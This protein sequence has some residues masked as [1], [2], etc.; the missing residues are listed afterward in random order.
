MYW[1]RTSPGNDGDIAHIKTSRGEDLTDLVR[2]ERTHG[3]QNRLCALSFGH[4]KRLSDPSPNRFGSL[5]PVEFDLATEEVVR[6]D[7][8]EEN[9]GIGGCRRGPTVA[10]AGW[11]RITPGRLWTHSKES[12]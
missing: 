10:V 2:H 11:T 1:P 8:A 6:V 9:I 4:T 7:I 5:G 3:S 12:E